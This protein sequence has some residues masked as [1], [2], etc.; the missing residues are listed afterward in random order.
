MSDVT[1]WH[2]PRCSKSRQTLAL[3]EENGV[4]PVVR[5]YL[6]DAPN[7]A[8]IRAAMGALGISAISMMR[9]KEA[10]FK[11]LGLSKDSD[12]AKLIAAMAEVPKLIERPVVFKDGKA[13]IGRPPEQVLE[14]L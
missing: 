4:V 6:T 10:E 7:E 3:I 11:E 12:E 1:I 8:E 2:N 13:R 14:I 5:P 9:T